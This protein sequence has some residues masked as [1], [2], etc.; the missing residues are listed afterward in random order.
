MEVLN[1]THLQWKVL[2]AQD[3]SVTDQV[4]IVKDNSWP[5]QDGLSI[6][7]QE[8]EPWVWSDDL[9]RPVPQPASIP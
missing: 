5:N 6:P 9:P 4:M 7:R 8:T 2:R 3:G 1:N